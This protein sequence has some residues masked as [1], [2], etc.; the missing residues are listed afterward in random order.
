MSLIDTAELYGEGHAEEVVGQA[1]KGIRD[2]VFLVSKVHP[3]NASRLGTVEACERSLERLGV[4]QLDL[5]LLHW[6]SDI[7]LVETIEAFEQLQASGKIARWGVSNFDVDDLEAMANLPN[8][9]H[10]MANQVLYNLHHRGIEYDLRSWSEKR[11]MPLMAYSPLGEGQLLHDPEVRRVA[12]ACGATPAQVAIAFILKT[13]N[14]IVI[15]KSS[16]VERITENHGAAKLAL[17]EEA[18]AALDKA[19]P[20]TDRKV[21]LELGW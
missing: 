1:L 11:S 3:R 10:A 21:P 18:I 13:N 8:G 9:R 20:P 16:S 4:E 2:Q 14:I 7:P 19:F 12:S 5:Y 15:P 17:T 6:K